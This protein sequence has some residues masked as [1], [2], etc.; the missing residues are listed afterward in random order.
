M[1]EWTKS[2]GV[3]LP[4]ALAVC[5]V[6]AV[7][8]SVLT[9]KKSEKIRR[10]PLMILAIVVF[11]LEI[12]KQTLSARGGYNLWSIPLHFCSLFL[13]FFPLAGFF[14][15]KVGQ[16]GRTMTF[17]CGSF[18]LLLFYFNPSTVIG[19]A[20]DNI[21]GSFSAFHTFTYHHIIIL[22]Y[23]IMVMSR[24]YHPSKKDF[25]YVFVGISVYAVVAISMA[26]ILN[27][28]FCNILRSN[29]SF[30]E[31]LRQSRG[32]VVYTLVMIITGLVGGEVIVLVPNLCRKKKKED[33]FSK[34]MKIL[35]SE[36]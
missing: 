3:V 17:T 28:N 36:V 29:I 7:V 31:A 8:I 32:Q 33:S 6:L 27:V 15:G 35:K 34:I 26:H 19:S 5:L 10:I 25:L 9:A 30:M 20:C 4:I 16:F 11:G 12:A 23:L 1:V 13:Y 24:L 22:F 14:G 21:F 18:F 2:E